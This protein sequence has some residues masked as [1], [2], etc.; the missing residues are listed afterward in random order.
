MYHL[1]NKT[2]RSYSGF[3]FPIKVRTIADLYTE[4]HLGGFN[5]VLTETFCY[6][7]WRTH[8]NHW[9][10]IYPPVTHTH[11]LCSK[12]PHSRRD[13]GN[14]RKWLRRFLDWWP[15]SGLNWI[16]FPLKKSGLDCCLPICYQHTWRGAL[17][18]PLCSR[19]PYSYTHVK[20]T[21]KLD[22]IL[23]RHVIPHMEKMMM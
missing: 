8:I 12:Y 2:K 10:I 21:C 20:P 11:S 14:Y 22:L 16:C 6:L 3:I 7:R 5:A 18:P 15:F 17:P 4:I 13:P 23:F 1:K 19:C 9:S